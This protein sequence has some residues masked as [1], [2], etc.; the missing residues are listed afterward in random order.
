MKI[1]SSIMND[2]FLLFT[3]YIDEKIVFLQKFY[4]IKL[5]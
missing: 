5:L 4:E 1:V 2:I 3:W